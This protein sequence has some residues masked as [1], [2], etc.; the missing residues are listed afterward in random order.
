MLRLVVVL[1]A[2]MCRSDKQRHSCSHP[3]LLC[4]QH[5][6]A[7]S[8]CSVDE[9]PSAVGLCNATQPCI[10]T[11]H[12]QQTRRPPPPCSCACKK[13]CGEYRSAML[14]E[15][16]VQLCSCIFVYHSSMRL[17]ACT[18]PFV[19]SR[20]QGTSRKCPT[21]MIYKQKLMHMGTVLIAVQL[22]EVSCL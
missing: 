10:H 19:T 4:D 11:T 3:S 9:G 15:S 6:H 16:T 7:A 8:T 1:C 2:C 13:Q 14:V 5:K 21:C 22:F 20:A 17:A 18:L 12:Y